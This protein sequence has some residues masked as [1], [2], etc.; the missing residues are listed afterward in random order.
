MKTHTKSNSNP[1]HTTKQHAVVIIQLNIVTCP[2]YPEKLIRDSVNALF[3]VVILPQPT[4][5][6]PF[7][8]TNSKHH[9]TTN[10]S[11]NGAAA[12][13]LMNISEYAGHRPSV[14]WVQ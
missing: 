12:L 14:S 4:N 8:N 11:A 2:T 13:A 6:A 10:P 7:L 1:K 5:T 3:S 9:R